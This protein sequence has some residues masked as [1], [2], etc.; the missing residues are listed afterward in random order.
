MTEEKT[1]EIYGVSRLRPATDGKGIRTLICT[2]GCPLKCKYCI[3][4]LSWNG[5]GKP[6][7]YTLEGLYDTVK[8][9]RLYWQATDGG[10]TFGGGEPLLQAQRIREF[11]DTYCDGISIVMETSINVPTSSLEVVIDVINYFY[12][13]I[14]SMNGQIYEAYT[15]KDNSQ[16]FNNL[17]FLVERVPDK[18]GVRIPLIKG[19][20]EMED[21][22]QSKRILNDMGIENTS[23]F[24]YRM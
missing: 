22:E 1:I 2:Y 4:P 23:I 21:C 3:N 12:V 5:K 8:L 15:G 6:K 14:K 17:R 20:N 24:K 19:Y 11:I 9:D 13:D 18:F 10:I 16:V 7:T